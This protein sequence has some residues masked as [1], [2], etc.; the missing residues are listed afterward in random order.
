MKRLFNNIMLMAASGIVLLSACQK[1]ETKVVFLGGTNPVLTSSI[2]DGDTI[3]L[4]VTDTTSLAVVYKWTNPNYQ[5]SNGVSSMNVTYYLQVDTVGANFS[6]PNMQT[7]AINSDLQKVFTVSSFNS[8]LGNGLQL[9]FGQPH[10]IEVRVQSF[11]QPFTSASP[12]AG[13]LNSETHKYIV[14]PFA[15]PPKVNPP[16]YGTLYIV[17]SAI[18]VSGWNNPISPASQVPVQQ[19]AQI[20]PTEFKLTVPIVGGGEYKF[21]GVNGSWGDQWSV[22]VNDDP[23]AINGGPFVFNGANTK[24]PAASGNYVIDVNFQTGQFTVTPQ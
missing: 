2:P 6:S 12:V 10:N 19:F 20:S 14:T 5:F 21:I 11:I 18:A 15:P 8:L 23:N 9:S 3:P 22:A 16:S 13:T 24:A 4:P 17:G 7:V 1:D